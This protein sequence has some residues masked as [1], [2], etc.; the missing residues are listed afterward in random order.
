M[1]ILRHKKTLFILVFHC[2]YGYTLLPKFSEVPFE[3]TLCT[4]LH[5]IVRALRDKKSQVLQVFHAFK[6]CKQTSAFSERGENTAWATLM[7]YGEVTAVF[8]SLKKAYYAGCN[9]CYTCA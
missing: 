5:D 1:E 6:G 3:F 7:S 4:A 9:R 2:C 8:T